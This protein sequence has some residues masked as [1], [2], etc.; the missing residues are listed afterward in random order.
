MASKITHAVFGEVEFDPE[1]DLNDWAIELEWSGRTVRVDV[2]FDGATMSPSVLDSLAQ[3][4]T[5]IAGFDELARQSMRQDFDREKSQ[6]REYIEHHLD[7]LDADALIQVFGTGDTSSIDAETFLAR[8]YLV[9]IGL[10][11]DAPD[12]YAVF[13]Y[14]LAE[15][16][17]GYLLAVT[18]DNRRKVAHIAMES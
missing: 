1:H 15:E 16:L 9:R 6:V 5:D 14:M 3:F 11:P 10:Y 13:D 4:V 8:M 12:G 7:E 17:S 18:L 2:T